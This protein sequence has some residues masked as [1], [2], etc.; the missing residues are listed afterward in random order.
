[1]NESTPMA[2]CPVSHDRNLPIDGTPLHPSPVL[3]QWRDEAAL[4]PLTFADGHR[5]LIATRHSSG[6]AVLTDPRFVRTPH[7][8]FPQPTPPANLQLDD[9]AK[10]A[11]QAG[12]ILDQDGE[13]HQRLRRAITSRFSVKAARSYRPMI[14][15]I[16]AE[17]LSSFV[18]RDQPA[19][20][21]SGYGD[22]IS[23]R[24]HTVLLGIPHELVDEY[25]RL[26]VVE[27]ETSIQRKFDYVRKVL[28]AKSGELG[29]D[30]LSDLLQSDL[31]E[32]AV[33]GLTFVLMVSGRDSVAYMVSTAVVAL[34]QNPD[35]LHVL[36]DRPDLIDGA[37]EEFMRVGAMFL[38]LFPRTATEDVTVDGVD[39]P[40]GATVAVS[41]VAVNHD[42]R[43]FDAPDRFDITRDAFGHFGFGFGIHG[44]VGQQVA[45]IEIKEAILQLVT[46]MPGLRLVDAEQARPLPFAHHVGAYR[47]GRV[48][49]SWS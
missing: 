35:Q 22:V 12:S 30:V 27:H 7:D 21:T 31:D 42:E 24:V 48:F 13:G 32:H 33:E 11:L 46:T 41:A 38:T 3:S 1:M 26:F 16:T 23:G 39:V 2:S 18:E 34:L 20:L 40:A 15:A 10:A 45:R 44:C 19:D 4:T 5:G 25:L 37:T 36:R 14:A 47:A 49:V 43:R 6:Q 29:D 8:R 9:R 28:D 17:A